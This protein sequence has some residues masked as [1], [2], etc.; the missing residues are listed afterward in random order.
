MRDPIGAPSES[1]TA[2]SKDRLRRNKEIALLLLVFVLVALAYSAI[3]PLYE[4]TDELRH[5]RFVRFI[6]EN[7]A[8]PVQG[9][10]GCSAQGHHPPLFYATAALLTGW[11]ETG[12]S[13]CDAPPDNPF[14]AYRYWEVGGDNKNQYLH[15]VDETFPWQG[16]ALAAH[17]SVKSTRRSCPTAARPGPP[18]SPVSPGWRPEPP[19]CWRRGCRPSRNASWRCGDSL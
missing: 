13:V 5:Y 1:A 8:L 2:S 19:C 14:W 12:R 9:Q 17:L 6:V 15:G 10:V 18:T 7:R 3:N 11:V 16:A 4:A